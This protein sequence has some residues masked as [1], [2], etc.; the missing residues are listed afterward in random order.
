M[1]T[2]KGNKSSY[3]ESESNLSIGI[4]FV[5]RKV[6][7]SGDEFPVLGATIRGS[8]RTRSPEYADGLRKVFETVGIRNFVGEKLVGDNCEENSDEVVVEENYVMVW[9][10][11][12]EAATEEIVTV[13]ADAKEEANWIETE[14]KEGNE[15]DDH[16]TTV[17]PGPWHRSIK[18]SV[19]V[20]KH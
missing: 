5:G 12:A 15:D 6:E 17:N 1:Y 3:S 19:L 8:S 14:T 18:R 7:E 9:L 11:D 16:S 2:D 13:K 4:A 20:F 10:D